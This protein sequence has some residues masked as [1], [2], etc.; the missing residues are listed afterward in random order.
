MK[1]IGGGRFLQELRGEVRKLFMHFPPKFLQYISS[2]Q[3]I[4]LHCIEVSSYDCCHQV[5]DFKAKMH[6][7]QLRLGLRPRPRWWSLRRSPRLPSRMGRGI[8]PPHTLPPRRLWRLDPRAFGVRLPQRLKPT[9]LLSSGTATAEK[10][11]FNPGMKERGGDE[12]LITVST[13]VSSITTV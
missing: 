12:I 5:S 3:I 9:L 1:K 2:T 8:P 6:Q 10:E 7:I 4:G 11:G 13:N